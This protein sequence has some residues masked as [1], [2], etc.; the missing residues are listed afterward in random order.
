MLQ[1]PNC[2]EYATSYEK[3]VKNMQMIYIFDHACLKNPCLLSF[4][5]SPSLGLFLR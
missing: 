3:K 2:G 1:R 5:V 4:M